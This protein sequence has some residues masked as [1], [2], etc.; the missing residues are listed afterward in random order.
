M[1][2]YIIAIDLGGTSAKLALIDLQ[3]N[4]FEKWSVITDKLNNGQNIV[5]NLL[6]SIKEKLLDFN[7]TVDN[8]LGVGMGSPGSVDHIN[9]TVIGAYNLNWKEKQ[10]IGKAFKEALDVPF[11]IENDANI[12]A[13]GEQWKGAGDNEQNVVMVTLGT[14]VGGGIVVGGELVHGSIGAAGEIGHLTVDPDSVIECTCGKT[15]CLEAVASAT[16]I[17]NL[18]IHYLGTFDEDTTLKTILQTE[19]H[20]TAV[21][22][23][24]SA[25]EGDVFSEMIVEK[26]AKYLGLACSHIANTLNP[27]KIVLGGGVSQAGEYLR[28][29]VE[30]YCYKYT[31]PPIRKSTN[32]AIANLGNDAGILGAAKIVINEQR[33]EESVN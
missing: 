27:S 3:G 13:V 1:K 19:D 6:H 26:F 11:Y 5:P 32:I 14:G 28:S 31:F 16:G 10:N 30:K 29:K 9:R 4:V 21:D 24:K 20:L 23:F 33:I 22:I 7:L 8:L 12:A 15:G 25:Q 18:A 17:V 2:E